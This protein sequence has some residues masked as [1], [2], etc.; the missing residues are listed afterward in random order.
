MNSSPMTSPKPAWNKGRVVGKKPPLAPEQVELIRLHLRQDRNLR[1]LALLNTAL[2]TCLRGS[3]LVRLRVSDV[4]TGAGM[5]ELVEIRQ[6]K[7]AQRRPEAVQSRLSPATRSSVRDW[8]LACDKPLH[9]W[10]F[11]GHG[12]RWSHKALSES[13]VWRLFKG[14]LI[15]AGIDPA[16]YGLHSLRRTLPTYIHQQTGNL[17]AAQLLLGHASIENTKGYIGVDQ[18]EAL[19]IAG[20]Y[21]L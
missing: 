1:D 21:H 5:R 16:L 14:W 12:A 6:K 20:K 18:A 13:Q 9:A 11:T 19:D 15:Q 8:I 7:T 3:D 10:L 4:A 2:D 17:R